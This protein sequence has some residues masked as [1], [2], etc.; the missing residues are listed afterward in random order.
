MTAF[1][2]FFCF[3]YAEANSVS[4]FFCKAKNAFHGTTI[5]PKIPGLAASLIIVV[6]ICTFLG[7]EI[8]KSPAKPGLNLEDH[9][10]E[11][12]ALMYEC[13]SWDNVTK[14]PR[15]CCSQLLH[16]LGLEFHKSLAKHGLNL[17]GQEGRAFFG[18]GCQESQ[19]FKLRRPRK[20][21][22]GGQGC[23]E[24]LAMATLAGLYQASFSR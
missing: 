1:V 9:F 22:F 20:P 18:Q 14:D 23:Q 10:C 4:L 16:L 11:K 6:H 13:P 7:L 19:A 5:W 2:E 3:F 12:L 17:E 24:S 15:F 8:R 21:G